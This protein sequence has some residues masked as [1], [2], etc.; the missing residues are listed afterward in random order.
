ML[1]LTDLPLL[2]ELRDYPLPLNP[3]PSLVRIVNSNYANA[4]SAFLVII[5]MIFFNTSRSK[6][7]GTETDKMKRAKTPNHF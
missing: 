6:D 3:G 4:A 5:L 1:Q 7:S 2:L